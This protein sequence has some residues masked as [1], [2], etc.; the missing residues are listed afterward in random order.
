MPESLRSLELQLLDGIAAS[1]QSAGKQ[2]E[3]LDAHMVTMVQAAGYNRDQDEALACLAVADVFAE[4]GQSGVLE[5]L[6]VLKLS[7]NVGDIMICGVGGTQCP[8]LHHI[9]QDVRL[10][11]EHF[12]PEDAP[13]AVAAFLQSEI[14]Q[15]V[16]STRA[17]GGRC[18]CAHL[19]ILES[20]QWFERMANL[21]AAFPSV[22]AQ[23]LGSLG[24]I[25]GKLEQPGIASKYLYEV[26]EYGERESDHRAVANAASSLGKIL[27]AVALKDYRTNFLNFSS[28][29]LKAMQAHKQARGSFSVLS[30][31]EEVAQCYFR[32]AQ[33]HSLLKEHHESISKL[34]FAQQ[35]AQKCKDIGLEAD[36]LREIGLQYQLLAQHRS[37][38][39]MHEA[40][41]AFQIK[42][43]SR[44]GMGRASRNLCVSHR[45]LGG[46]KRALKLV[47]S[48]R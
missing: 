6:L 1:L 17:T 4:K 34:R 43:Q 22:R 23:A 45:A 21:A 10:E 11:E 39:E 26:I 36:A 8:T 46:Q 16:S 15:L 12:C 3:A 41:Y 28:L 40:D 33:G 42:L 18:F 35:T 19:S 44:T 24:T 32:I 47:V 31:V 25:Y 20:I 2:D 14:G 48:A 5:S 9:L 29:Q 37:A 30:D 13:P 7:K 38:E 27:D